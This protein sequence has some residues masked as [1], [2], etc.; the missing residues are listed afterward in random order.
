MPKYKHMI[1]FTEHRQRLESKLKDVARRKQNA[2]KRKVV[3]KDCVHDY[4]EFTQTIYPE[5]KY[6]EL[7][8]VSMGKFQVRGCL[9]CHKKIYTDYKVYR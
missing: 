5:R 9:K 2:F 7:P 4:Q 6:G 8:N 3:S 1:N